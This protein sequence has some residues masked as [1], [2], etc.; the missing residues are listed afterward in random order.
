LAIVP[1]VA[2]DAPQ[3]PT[4]SFSQ[5]FVDAAK[6]AQ[7]AVVSIKSR[8]KKP[9][10]QWMQ[11][12]EEM[13]P[14]DIWEKFFGPYEQRQRQPQPA[15][16]Y[17]SGFIVSPDGY[18]LTNNHLAKDA[19]SITVQMFDG[20]EFL[21][22]KIGC[23]PSTDIAVLKID[24][25]NLPVLALADSSNVEIGEWVLAIGNPFGL[26]ASVT[27]GVISAKGRSDLD[28]VRVEKFFQT[29]A[30]INMGN[31]GGPLINLYGDVIGMNTAI[32]SHT[33][34]YLGIGFAIPS[35]LLKDVMK[36]LIEHGQLVRGYLGI[37]MQR[38]DAELATAIGLEKAHGALVSEVIP[39]SPADKAGLRSG[40][41][42]VG[43]DGSEI[44]SV[45]A[46]RGA[47]ALK[48]PGQTIQLK[49]LRDGKNIEITSEVAQN[50]ETETLGTEVEDTF[51]LLLEPVTPEL[52]RKYNLDAKSGLLIVQI[53]PESQAYRAGLRA[54]FVILA[55]NGH[56]V[57]T[58]EEFAK[59]ANSGKNSGRIL[60]QVK[61][62]PNIR[63]V[64]ISAE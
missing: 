53:D 36:E 47:I 23:D 55:V 14:E 50:P 39:E 22:K 61:I 5:P 37:A 12:K 13:L 40:D 10:R 44:E 60:L 4:H 52:V 59:A 24:G 35:N 9:A 58:V 27:T 54:G 6:K 33:G 42:I 16:A 30:A 20:N 28:I 34:G 2:A 1:L 8:I 64:P 46:L 29:D 17:G 38:I 18:I 48:K 62:G 25:K 45:G 7:P 11:D 19:D 32:A 56:L 51:G 3:K 21:A 31:S 26:Q 63:F 49:I 41:V 15:F 43:A 57:S